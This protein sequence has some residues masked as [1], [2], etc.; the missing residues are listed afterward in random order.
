MVATTISLVILF[1]WLLLI[2]GA[3]SRFVKTCILKHNVPNSMS[4]VTRYLDFDTFY[5]C[6]EHTSGEV[7][8]YVPNNVED[9]KKICFSIWKYIYYGCTLEKIHQHSF[10]ESSVHFSKPL[11][12]ID[13]DFLELSILSYS[14]YKWVITFLDNYFFYYNIAFLH[15]KS[16]AT[17]A[18]KSIFQMQSN[19]T[20]NS[21]K[22]LHT[23]N[24]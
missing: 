8:C 21:L 16:E 19:N 10:S 24:R 13:S 3:I 17:E 22:R 11:G 7:M 15:K 14:K 20:S 9:V 18:I 1:Y 6:F 12:L 4:L 5:H 23:D 2:F